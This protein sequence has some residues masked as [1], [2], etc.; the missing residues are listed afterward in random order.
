MLVALQHKGKLTD[1]LTG[2]GW[3]VFAKALRGL[4]G[5]RLTR[6]GQFRSADD[7]HAVRC[8]YKASPPPPA[9]NRNRLI[10]ILQ[11]NFG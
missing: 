8:S 9:T 2:P 10:R 1:T 11:L 3:E 6:P 7:G 5:A 4:S